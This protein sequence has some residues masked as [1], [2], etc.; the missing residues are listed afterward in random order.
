MIP[1]LICVLLAYAVT[2][3]LSLGIFDV[4][5]EMRNLPYLPVLKSV[6][7]YKM[8]AK[9]IMNKNFLYLIENSTLGEAYIIVHQ[10]GA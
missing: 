4:M 1:T 8:E 3:S 9:H 2:N 5:T 6:E 7:T 10:L